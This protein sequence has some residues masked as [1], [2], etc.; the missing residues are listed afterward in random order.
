MRT[1]SLSVTRACAR[2]RHAGPSRLAVTLVMV[3]AV[4]AACSSVGGA[5][6]ATQTVEIRM[7]TPRD[8]SDAASVE[9]GGLTAEDLDTL[10]AAGLTDEQ[11]ADLLR[12]TVTSQATDGGAAM[13]PV[14]G[15][16]AIGDDGV[17]RFSPMF[18]FDP[19]VGIRRD[20]TRPGSPGRRPPGVS[21][22]WP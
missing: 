14:L 8:G 22:S 13:P 15:S 19:V 17:L 12:V 21:R 2:P 16:Y 1:S 20:S 4:T 11:W 6:V 3:A 10:R 18:P 9:V 5:D 7:Q